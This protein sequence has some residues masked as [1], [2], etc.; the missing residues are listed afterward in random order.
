MVRRSYSSLAQFFERTGT[1]Q[2]EFAARLG[3]SQP[4]L[5]KIV[6]GK[7]RVRLDLALRIAALADIPVSSLAEKAS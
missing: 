6:N 7:Q 2:E 1:T 5:S 4:H 3:I